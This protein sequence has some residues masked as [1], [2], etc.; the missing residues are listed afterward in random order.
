MTGTPTNY[1][2]ELGKKWNIDARCYFS[3]SGEW[4]APP[5]SF[6]LALCDPKGYVYFQNEADLKASPGVQVSARINIP[7]GISKLPGYKLMVVD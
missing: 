7:D 4:Y 2:R 1:G 3:K 6:P 5:L